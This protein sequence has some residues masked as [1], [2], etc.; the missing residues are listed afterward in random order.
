VAEC[1]I[2]VI[3]TI[4]KK[5]YWNTAGLGNKKKGNYQNCIVGSPI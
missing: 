3:K 4:D 1:L 5:V 2:V